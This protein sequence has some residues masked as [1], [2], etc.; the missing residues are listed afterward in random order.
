MRNFYLVILFLITAL[1]LKGQ[2][3]KAIHDE[4]LLS[5]NKRMVFESWGDFKPLKKYN[6]IGIQTNK[7]YGWMWGTQLAATSSTRHKRNRAYRSG[8]DIR[9]L[10]VGGKEF[11]RHLGAIESHKLSEDFL[12]ETD[13]IKDEALQEILYYNSTIS[14]ADPLY[15]LYFQ[16]TLKPIIN[17]NKNSPYEG[18]K[19]SQSII[20]RFILTGF[21]DTFIKEMEVLKDRLNVAFDSDMPRGKRIILYHN[22]LDEYRRLER[23]LN[24]EI[25]IAGIMV[26]NSAPKVNLYEP[27]DYS[28]FSPISDLELMNN[29]IHNIDRK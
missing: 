25:T 7:H 6:W 24:R 27:I 4:A 8:D 13:I 9:P 21:N 3:V 26:K 1:S 23:L 17:F 22:L 12:K 20:Q 16:K 11:N 14:K 18:H 5:H 29:I 15:M 19:I 28:T 10:R 2:A